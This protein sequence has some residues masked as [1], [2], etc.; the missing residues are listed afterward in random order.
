ML[1][2][3]F[4]TKRMADTPRIVQQWAG[5]E[6]RRSRG[7]LLRQPGELALRPGT[8]IVLPA[9]GRAGHAAPASGNRGDESGGESRL[10]QAGPSSPYPGSSPEAAR[11][12]ASRRHHAVDSADSSS[13]SRCHS[14]ADTSTT[15]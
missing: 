12:A 14:S 11:S 7:D 8:H 15:G 3:V 13:C 2:G 4:V 1:P 10:I 6:L 9:A 5:D